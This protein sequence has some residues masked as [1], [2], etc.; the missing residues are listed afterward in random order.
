M[1]VPN[2]RDLE[3]ET[4]MSPRDAF[5]AET[6]DIPAT[7]AA[8]R[9]AAEHIT[10]YPPGIPVLLPGER[11]GAAA[12]EYLLDGVRPGMVTPDATDPSLSRSRMV[13]RPRH[14]GIRMRWSR[15]CYP[16]R[17]GVVAR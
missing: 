7:P 14:D 16:F 17:F 2:P 1:T 4:V 12:L 9:V 8:G 6:E 11:I 3:L 13:A 10:P 5:F 15:G